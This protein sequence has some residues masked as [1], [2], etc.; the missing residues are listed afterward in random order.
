MEQLFYSE[1]NNLLIKNNI[2]TILKLNIGDKY[3][4]QWLFELPKDSDK[5]IDSAI[6]HIGNEVNKINLQE[7]SNDKIIEY[8]QLL[9]KKVCDITIPILVIFFKFFRIKS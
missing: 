9:N 8:L 6:K 7:F 2:Y 4:N 3:S 5:I 1:K